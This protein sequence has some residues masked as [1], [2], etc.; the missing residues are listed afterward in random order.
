MAQD[1][2]KALQLD[3]DKATAIRIWEKC[4]GNPVAMKL[5]AQA[6][7]R[8]SVKQLLALPLP[9]WSEGAAGWMDEL[10]DDLSEPAKESAKRLSLFDEPVEGP[11]LLAIG[12]TE[13]GLGEL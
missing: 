4:H 11:L 5:F 12:A 6:A 7:R 2:L 13:E 10:L 9:N 8:R 3:V 1:Y